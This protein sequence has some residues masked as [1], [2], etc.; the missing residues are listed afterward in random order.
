MSYLSE[1]QIRHSIEMLI[2][3][4]FEEVPFHNLYLLNGFIEQENKR[5]G[6]CSDKVLQFQ[7]VL[8]ENGITSCLHSSFINGIECHRLLRIHIADKNY[9]ADIGSGWPS[10]YLFPADEVL[11]YDAYG[12]SFKTVIKKQQILLFR[13]SQNTY[14]QMVNIPFFEKPKEAIMKDIKSR[15]ENIS[16][17][18]FR[19]SLRFSQVVNDVFYFLRGTDLYIYKTGCPPEIQYDINP[20]TIKRFITET[21]RFEIG[22]MK[23]YFPEVL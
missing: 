7:K 14:R 17:Y 11:E 18:P 19:R 9:F 13:K 6:T 4:T 10:I 3:K 20:I 21:C 15:F 8:T 2:K 1:I 22:Q 12:I 16:I 5:G 23:T